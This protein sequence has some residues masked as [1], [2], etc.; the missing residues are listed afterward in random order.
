[1]THFRCV[2]ASVFGAVAFCALGCSRT[3]RVPVYPVTGRVLLDS[4][5]LPNATVFLHPQ[6]GGTGL[7]PVGHTRADGTFD[8]TTYETADGAPVGEYRVTVTWAVGKHTDKPEAA[9]DETVTV[10]SPAEYASPTKTPLTCTVTAGPNR[11]EPFKLNGKPT[12]KR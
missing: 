7:R 3:D 11:L 8:V 6:G 2:V 9:A 4:K 1:V 5:P 10:Q 12:T